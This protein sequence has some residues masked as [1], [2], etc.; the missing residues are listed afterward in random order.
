VNRPR[1]DLHRDVVGDI[2]AGGSVVMAV[3]V[4]ADSVPTAK[5]V[6][7]A[8]ACILTDNDVSRGHF[9]GAGRGVS[10][11]SDE[12]HGRDQGHSQNQSCPCRH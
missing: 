8:I 9:R 6:L 4:A 11:R 1:V 5:V 2:R 12:K 3:T 7:V 10:D